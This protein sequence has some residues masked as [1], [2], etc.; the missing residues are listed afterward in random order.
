M[1]ETVGDLERECIEEDCD[2]QE[3][4]EVY[5]DLTISSDLLLKFHKC[6]QVSVLSICK[7]ES[8]QA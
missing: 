3:F 4:H 8:F 6:K 5:D 2:D 7:S 1:W